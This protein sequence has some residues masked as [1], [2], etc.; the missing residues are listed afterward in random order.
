MAT[1]KELTWEFHKNAERQDFARKLLKGELP[2]ELYAEYLANQYFI[3]EALEKYSR[4]AG[5][6]EGIEDICRADAIKKDIDELMYG[7]FK[8]KDSALKYRNWCEELYKNTPEQLL[9]HIYVRHFGDLHGG[10]MIA[11]RVPGEGHYYKF[12]G[13]EKELIAEVR[14]RLEGK[15]EL[16]MNEAI[17]C[18]EF[19]TELF[20]EL[21]SE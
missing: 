15:E 5:I 13:K 19:A 10:Q 11:K 12:N 1:L 17:K 7:G 20:K 18:F 21:S 4:K 2:S 3:Y 6:L 16:F 14:S 9:A 8:I